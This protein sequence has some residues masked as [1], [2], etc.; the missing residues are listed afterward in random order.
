MK[1]FLRSKFYLF[2]F[3]S[4]LFVSFSSKAQYFVGFEGTGETKTAYASGSVTL[5]GLSWNLT[6]ALI[7]TEAGELITGVRVAR[8]RGYGTSSMTMLE[9]KP[10]GLGTISF[11]YRRYGTDAQVDWVVQYSK[12]DG[13]D[14]IQI[15]DVF[16]A[17]AS[18]EIRT[19]S[20]AVNVTGN[21]RVR[22]KRGTE[23]GTANR[24]L[25]IDDITITNF[26]DPGT[27]SLTNFAV[28]PTAANT[29]QQVTFTWDA[30]DV[31]AIK[32]QAFDGE[33]W[34]DLEEL[35]N[36]NASLGTINFVIPDGA[37]EGTYLLRIVD[38]NNSAVVSNTASIV[39]SDVTFAG[40]WD[41]DGL[42]PANDAT[43]VPIDLFKVWEYEGGNVMPTFKTLV[44]HFKER[45]KAGS[46]SI[47]LFKA[48]GNVLVYNFDVNTAQVVFQD[49][50]VLIFLPD[51]LLPNTDYY[52][53][54][55]NG[56]ITDRASTPNAFDGNVVWEFR[57]GA[58]DSQKAIAEIREP[59]DLNVSDVSPYLNQYVITSGLVIHKRSNGV[60]IQDNTLPW[61]GLFVFD[62]KFTPG[63]QVGDWVALIGKVSAYNNMTQLQ[64]ILSLNVTGQFPLPEPVVITMPFNKTNSEQ[65]ESMLVKVENVVHTTEGPA[66]TGTEFKVSDG[67]NI[68]IIDDYQYNGF[69]P[70]EGQQFS[71]IAGIMNHF[72]AD[73]KLAP[74]NADDIV[75]KP[76]N[77]K[78]TESVDLIIYPNPVINEIRL[79]SSES[80]AKVEVTNIAGQMVA[81]SFKVVGQEVV[82]PVNNNVN[83]VIIVKI[84]T[85]SGKV[86]VKK[87]LKQ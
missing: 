55:D 79:L 1:N 13:V 49:E 74:R 62:S 48:A 17:P 36:V 56:A 82:V 10:D 77:V 15:G 64:N 16:T 38:R 81:N 87:V 29:G 72:Q 33:K 53:T 6:E 41:R 50:A 65:W 67:T 19:F 2:V 22:I 44:M 57:T 78:N 61:G 71:Y 47:K 51:N 58:R 7:G 35:T 3:I 40:L 60:Y 69:T 76:T 11:K 43:D 59:I 23:T 12:N 66:V 73:Y 84:T 45:V 54:I 31:S 5:S 63:V 37:E 25:N 32:F 46:G 83:G 85:E 52:V 80:V 21:I 4:V 68:G 75:T 14:W 70:T 86:V 28:T 30:I 39:V 18:D 42:Y 34:F 9:N 8:L 20:Q 26:I 27:S 24:R